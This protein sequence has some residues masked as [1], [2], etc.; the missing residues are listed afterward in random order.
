M[1][2]KPK[3][4]LLSYLVQLPRPPEKANELLKSLVVVRLLLQ[5]GTVA[6]DRLR[7][8]RLEEHDLPKRGGAIF[9]SMSVHDEDLSD[10]TVAFFY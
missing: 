3:G 4:W 9:G 1:H 10:T 5:N 7:M 6:L 2:A 8:I